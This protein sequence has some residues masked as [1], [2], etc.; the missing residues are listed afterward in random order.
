[1]NI[2]TQ[3]SLFEESEFEF[4]RDLERLQLLFTQQSDTCWPA[5]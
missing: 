3:M 2:I 1:M 5:A 4:S